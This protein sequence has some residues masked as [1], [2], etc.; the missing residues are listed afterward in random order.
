MTDFVVPPPK[1]YTFAATPFWADEFEKDGLPDPAKWGYDVGNSGWGNNELQNYTNANIKNA[2]IEN[3]ILT[4]EAIKEKLGTSN[5]T[6]AR[7]VTKGKNDFLYGRI[8]AK[9][10]IPAGRGNWPAIWM[11]A[12]QSDYGTQ[13]WPDNGEIDILEHVGYDP[14]VMHASVHTKAY[15]HVIGT[16]KT[17]TTT[18]ANWDTEFHTFRVDWTPDYVR[19]FIDDKQYFEFKNPKGGWEQWPFDKKQHIL[20]NLAIGG[21]WGGQKGV[22]D[23]IFPNKFQIDYIRVYAL[24]P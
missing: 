9:A 10:K 22:D 5:Y 12:S 7:L 14:G 15:N 21:N 8:E 19:A 3:G 2:H 23:T 24:N 6:S 18:L 11:L 4:I 1:E 13:Y 16:Q 20:M 17:A